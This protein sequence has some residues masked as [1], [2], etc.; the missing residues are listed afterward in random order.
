MECLIEDV[1]PKDCPGDINK[2]RNSEIK[3]SNYCRCELLSS[4]PLRSMSG[5]VACILSPSFMVIGCTAMF[6]LKL[7]I[8]VPEYSVMGA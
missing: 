4:V 8:V 6:G 1:W 2:S 3:A 5:I 7:A